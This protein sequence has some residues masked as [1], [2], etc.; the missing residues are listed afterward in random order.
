MANTF[1]PTPHQA[2]DTRLCGK[3]VVE[4]SPVLNHAEQRAV[5]TTSK[6]V[7]FIEREWKRKAEIVRHTRKLWSDE[8]TQTRRAYTRRK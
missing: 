4:S 3:A 1:S 8:K 5:S 7:N 2:R 6:K